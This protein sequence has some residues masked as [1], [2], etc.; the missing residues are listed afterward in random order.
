MR[1]ILG[2]YFILT[3]VR[4]IEILQQYGFT[5]KEAKIYLAWLELGSAPASSIAR[6][7]NEIRSTVYSILK[8]FK[9][10]GI[11]QEI[12]RK[13]ISYFSVISPEMLLRKLEDKYATFKARVPELMAMAEK[14][15]NMPKVQ[16]FEGVEWIKQ[17]CNMILE[18]THNMT[19][20][21]YIL[22]FVGTNSIHKSIESFFTDEFPKL[23]KQYHV[24]TKAI[25]AWD[26]SSYAKYN[27][28][29]HEAVIIDDPLF[30]MANEIIVYWQNKVAILLYSEEEMS[31]V[32]IESTTLFQALTSMFS[33]LRKVFNKKSTVSRWKK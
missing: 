6:Q 26:N 3:T 22:S 9:K 11:V 14:I 4:M 20:T 30:S 12:K 7:A 23:R 24:H 28:K 15:G 19:K 33:I 18:D 8:E 25:V 16:F 13:E 31:A 1:I 21:D 29:T 17:T 27:A 32:V 2:I 10:Q 5:E